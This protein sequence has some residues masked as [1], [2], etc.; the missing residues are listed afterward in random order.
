MRITLHRWGKHSTLAGR[1]HTVQLKQ[2][3][4]LDGLKPLSVS[5]SKS[6]YQDIK[7]NNLKVPLAFSLIKTEAG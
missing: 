4:T 7:E 3:Q 5:V 1:S 6:P 2:V